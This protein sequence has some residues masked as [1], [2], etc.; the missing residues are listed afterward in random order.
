MN[1]DEKKKQMRR[2]IRLK[3]SI[4]T[5]K[6]KQEKSAAILEKL[7]VMDK[8]IKSST[9]ML[10]WSM[11]DEVYTH[12]FI[13]R[14]G[15]NKRIILPSVNGNELELKEYR[16]SHKLIAGEGFGILEPEGSVF[17]TPE[18]IELIV[19]PGVAFDKKN[20]RIGR[21]RGYYDKFLRLSEA[22]K[23]GI[24]FDFQLLDEIPVDEHDILMDIVITE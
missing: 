16:G 19:V 2:A 7:E 13:L 23:V 21:G 5:L 14:H 3:K 15:K 22:Y 4:Y 17:E 6:E 24:C 12:D 20:N 9:I 18:D 10:Y 8:F 11:D 1:I